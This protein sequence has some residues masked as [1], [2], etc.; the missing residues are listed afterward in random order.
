V[1]DGDWS[2][3]DA[4]EDADA[5]RRLYYVAMTRAGQTLMLAR[6]DRPH[7]LLD[8]LGDV[9]RR[10][11][12]ALPQP[13]PEQM[14]AYSRR[15]RRLILEEVFIDFA[16]RQPPQAKI[17]QALAAMQ[18][19]TPLVLNSRNLCDHRGIHVGRLADGYKPPPGLTCLHAEVAAIVTRERSQS[20]PAY[21]D[22][23]QCDTWEVLLPDLIYGPL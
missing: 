15:Y 18:P 22:K 12:I 9:L 3:R 5:A 7:P 17:H 1:L 4:K 2:R 6:F 8:T 20:S 21:Q 10:Q 23:L 14:S 13:T 19:G 16:G 11:P